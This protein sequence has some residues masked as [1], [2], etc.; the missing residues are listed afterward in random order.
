VEALDCMG[1]CVIEFH[2][3]CIAFLPGCVYLTFGSIM[4][5]IRVSL[6]KPSFWTVM[7]WVPALEYML[8]GARGLLQLCPILS[9]NERYCPSRP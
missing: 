5:C 6:V 7:G 2:I 8:S 4:V 3:E 9:S 1:T